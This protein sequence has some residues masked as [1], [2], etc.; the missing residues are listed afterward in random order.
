MHPGA[1]S[2]L[3]CATAI[4]TWY[5][6]KA[7]R[8]KYIDKIKGL[9]YEEIAKRGGGIK[10]SARMMQQMPEDELFESSMKRLEGDHQ[11]MEQEPL[12]S[13]AVMD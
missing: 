10:N 6:R 4:P 5:I 2:F 11:V 12:K 7:G 1:W 13:K 9:S 3:A 8:L